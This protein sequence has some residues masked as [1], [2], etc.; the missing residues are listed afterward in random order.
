MPGNPETVNLK[1]TSRG[2]MDD[3]HAQLIDELIRLELNMADLYRVFSV[4]FRK[5]TEFWRELHEEEKRHALL[6]KNGR[7]ILYEFPG[8]LLPS[9][10]QEV[11]NTNTILI[12]LIKKYNGKP[13]SRVSAFKVALSFEESVGEVH[14][15]RAMDNLP[16]SITLEI[17]Q[18]LNNND[19]DHAAR[20]SSYMS[21]HGIQ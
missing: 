12:S 18:K 9:T 11:L 1:C 4:L 8:E 21:K 20:I 14:Y 15:Q 13:P 16:T 6:L 10:L 2:P 7:D 3:R 19:K 5:D 17:F